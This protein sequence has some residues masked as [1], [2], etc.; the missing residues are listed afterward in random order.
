MELQGNLGEHA[1]S[2]GLKN[3]QDILY[4][5]QGM[6]KNFT[7]D[8][9]F[10]HVLS[11]CKMKMEYAKQQVE[12]GNEAEGLTFAQSVVEYFLKEINTNIESSKE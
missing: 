10:G 6:K 3:F 9:H 12:Q 5:L 8:D 1:S 2:L 7:K 4:L 11:Y